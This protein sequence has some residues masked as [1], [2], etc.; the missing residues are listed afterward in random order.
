MPSPPA[1]DRFRPISPPPPRHSDQYYDRQPAPPANGHHGPAY[2][3][4]HPADLPYRPPP[5]DAHRDYTRPRS[6]ILAPGYPPAPARSHAQAPLP[7]PASA[8]D[9]PY[10]PRAEYGRRSAYDYPATSPPSSSLLDRLRDG[11]PPADHYDRREYR[12]PPPP[13][14]HRRDVDRSPDQ[15][16]QREPPPPSRRWE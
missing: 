3:K 11:P 8:Y 7:L 14:P 1:R 6:P 9:P 10:E 4:G 5:L 13:L 12:G 15:R 16:W 2:S